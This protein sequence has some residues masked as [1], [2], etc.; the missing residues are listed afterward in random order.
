MSLTEAALLFAAGVAAGALNAI[1][2]GGT[3]VT[4]PAAVAIAG[5]AL[6]TAAATST[7]ALAP[8]AF[9][10]AWAY[11]RQLTSR[12][13]LA[14]ALALPAI[15]GGLIG[16]TLLDGLD[17]K[18]FEQLVPWLVFGATIAIVC[19]ESLVRWNP[20]AHSRSSSSPPR[21]EPSKKR[22]ALVAAALL[23]LSVYGGYFGA[24]ASILM[25]ALLCVGL[26]LD[27]V[28]GNAVKAFLIGALNL[29][30]AAFFV[31]RGLAEL[32]VAA[33]IGLGAVGGGVSGAWL[34]QRVPREVVR[35]LVML[36][37]VTLSAVLAYRQLAA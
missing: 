14:L 6:R 33:V 32:P 2:G 1:A 30:A 4:F 10:A 16:A 9:A 3:F 28:E 36:I 26:E 24:G 31:A 29:V 22:L 18:L 21:L 35:R 5:L 23:A 8:G 12:R 13:N 17:G 11:R 19:R 20:R 27:V 34:A 37:G 25:L 15:I 7:V